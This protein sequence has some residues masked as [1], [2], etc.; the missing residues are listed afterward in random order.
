LVLFPSSRRI[1]FPLPRPTTDNLRPFTDPSQTLLDTNST[2]DH[3]SEAHKPYTA[4]RIEIERQLAEL[5]DLIGRFGVRRLLK[6]TSKAARREAAGNT[7]VG[8]KFHPGTS[9]DSSDEEGQEEKSGEKEQEVG[10]KE[11]KRL[12]K[13][14]SKAAYRKFDEIVNSLGRTVQDAT[15]SIADFFEVFAKYVS[16]LS[17]STLD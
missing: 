9:S 13:E 4:K 12:K 7:D 17:S 3:P 14:E 8:A 1:L 5:A 2:I 16:S 10:R 11:A 6:G 15:G